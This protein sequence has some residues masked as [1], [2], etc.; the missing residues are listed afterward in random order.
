MTDFFNGLASLFQK[1]FR[2]LENLNGNFNKTIIII[3]AIACCIW[4]W[5]MA[6]YNKEAEQKGTLK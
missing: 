5:R 3:G 2:L 4:I 1:S 6:Q